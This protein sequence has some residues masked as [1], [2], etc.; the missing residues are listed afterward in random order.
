MRALAGDLHSHPEGWA[1]EL[2]LQRPWFP[3]PGRPPALPPAS[4]RGLR[5][6]CA[7][8]GGRHPARGR[9]QVNSLE[10][11]ASSWLPSGDFWM[12]M[13]E[14]SFGQT[15]LEGFPENTCPAHQGSRGLPPVSHLPGVDGSGCQSTSPGGACWAP[16]V[17]RWNPGVRSV[18]SMDRMPVSRAFRFKKQVQMR[19]T[20]A[21]PFPPQLP[22]PLG[23]G[24][25]GMAQNSCVHLGLKSTLPWQYKH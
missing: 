5:A 23:L 17:Q 15:R 8:T 12:L 14:T 19:G 4:G 6:Q 13:G 7:G 11:F 9:A 22:A 1:W 2:G 24:L 18:L 20:Q 3:W 10:S 25:Q 21:I 16:R